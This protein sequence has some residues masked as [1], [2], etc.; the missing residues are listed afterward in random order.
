MPDSADPSA[1][2]QE[3]VNSVPAEIGAELT[4]VILTYNSADTLEECL[5]S[6]VAQHLRR[7]QVL[8]VDDESNDETL[9]IV[10][11][12]AR[13]G[14]LRVE[15]VKNGAHNISRGRNI[16]IEAAPTPIVAFLDSDAYAD[17][18]WTQ[19]IVDTFAAPSPPALLAGVIRLVHRNDFARAI[20]LSDGAIARLFWKDVLLL[21]GCNFALNKDVLG[22]YRFN[23]QF[24]HTED[25]EFTWRV[26]QSF[27]WR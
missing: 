12:F 14:L 5:Q 3:L 16:G 23:E 20:A 21:S 1:W 11:R 19:A 18:Q 10:D 25:V 9:D 15:V 8:I 7:F 26:Q 24:I 4:V 2:A 27:D 6:L 22:G 17:P 13:M